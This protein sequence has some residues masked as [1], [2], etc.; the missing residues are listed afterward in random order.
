[1]AVEERTLAMSENK[2]P[3]R[4]FAPESQRSKMRM[5]R[6]S[7]FL[8]F[9]KNYDYIEDEIGRKCSMHGHYNNESI[10]IVNTKQTKP[11]SRTK[12]RWKHDIK[13]V[14]RQLVRKVQLDLSD[15][16]WGLVSRLCESR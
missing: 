13:M 7:Q 12:R 1:M 6:A 16:G 5:H 10:L 9:A 11:L 8:F 4:T 14:R 3:T 2:V 15:S